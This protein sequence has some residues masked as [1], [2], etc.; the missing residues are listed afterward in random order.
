M[1][2]QPIAI[3]V[4][5]SRLERTTTST[6][7]DPRI[8]G[9]AEEVGSVPRSGAMASW[10][11]STS[12]TAQDDLDG[13]LDAV[14]PLAERLV[15]KSGEFYPF[16][17]VVSRQ[18]ETSL[19]AADPGVGE[20]PTSQDVLTQL[21][22]AARAQRDETRAFAFV[23]DVQVNGSDAIRVELEHEEGAALV[24]L[25]PYAR[26]RFKKSVTLGA[27]SASQGRRRIWTS[28]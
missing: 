26:N 23:A 27:M 1:S 9:L 5:A 2:T 19:T 3:P 12:Q 8:Q 11:D 15:R 14:L 18:G 17:G 22:E 7:C 20:H 16:G 13:L 4:R 21:H 24:V 25:L 6:F 10:R 28:E